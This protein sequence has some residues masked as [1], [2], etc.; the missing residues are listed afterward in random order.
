MVTAHLEKLLWD[1]MKGVIQEV[2]AGGGAG[3]FD[4]GLN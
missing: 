2:V 4:R 1:G 3:G